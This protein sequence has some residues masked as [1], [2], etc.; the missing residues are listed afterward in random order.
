MERNVSPDPIEVYRERKDTALRP[1]KLDEYI[2]QHKIKGNLKVYINAAKSRKESLDHVLFSGPPG[3]G[4]T[5]LSQILA[6][7]LGV[8]MVASSGP[9]LEKGGDLAAIITNL[10]EH[11]ILFID[12]IHRLS[13]HVEEILYGAMEDYTLDIVIGQGPGAKSIKIDLA[14]FT[15]VGATTRTGLLSSP[16]RDRFGIIERLDYYSFEELEQIANRSAKLLE[17]KLSSDG[18]HE[19]ARRSRGTP[20]ITN[21]ILKRIRDFAVEKNTEVIDKSLADYALTRLDIDNNGLDYMDKKL[22]LT[23]IDK[24]AGGP[25]GL[26]TLAAATGEEAGTL[27]DV[28]EPYLIRE[29]FIQRTPRGRVATQLAHKYFNRKYTN[30]LQEELAFENTK[31]DS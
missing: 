6:N 25:V 8:D 12:E 9:A 13:R 2:G 11:D 7:E 16:L 27:E 19:V 20:R 22:M 26:D 5:T 17:I 31:K 1:T 24:F 21:R 4:K 23:I 14:K 29:G 10:K 30:I 15:L 28:Y 3:L 18:A